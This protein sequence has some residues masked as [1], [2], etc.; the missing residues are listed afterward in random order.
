MLM[1]PL[2]SPFGS[3]VA[4]NETDVLAGVVPVFGLTVIQLADG[5]AVNVWA[6][7]SLADKYMDCA[8]GFDAPAPPAK[9]RL[10][11]PPL[12]ACTTSTGTELAV[13]STFTVTVAALV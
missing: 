4:F 10:I 5:V 3:D 12:L 6:E 9:V 13:T 8:A 11:E 1:L 7:L 2:L